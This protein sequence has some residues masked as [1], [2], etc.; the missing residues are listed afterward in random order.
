VL[1]GG[2]AAPGDRRPTAILLGDLGDQ[3]NYALMQ[4]AFEY[5][6]AG[7]E[8]VTCSRDR[9]YRRHDRLVLDVGPFVAALEH[10]SGTTALLAGKPGPRMFDEALA[11]L[12]LERAD[13]S[14]VLMIG[15]DMHADIAGA[16]QAGLVAWA[17]ETGKFAAAAAAQAGIVPDRIIPGLETLLSDLGA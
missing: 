10:A 12:K 14:R 6:Q 2:T 17:V 15:D 16:Q 4:E 5:L 7:A 8:F 1:H 9:M 3:W 13:R 11:Q